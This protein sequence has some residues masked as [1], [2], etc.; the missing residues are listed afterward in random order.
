MNY[1]EAHDNETLFDALTYKL[2]TATSMD[3]R[4]RMQS[5]ALATTALSQG[6]SFWTAGGDQLRSKSFDRN[7]Y[8]S[9]DWFNVLDWS[10]TDNGFGRGLPPAADNEAKWDAMRPLLAEPDLKPRGPTS[11]RPAGRPTRCSRSAAAHPLFALRTRTQVQQKVSFGAGG[12]DQ[13][14][15]VIT[16]RIDDTAARGS[17]GR[18]KGVVVVFNASPEATTQPWRARPAGASPCTRSRPAAAT[19]SSG[20]RRT[21]GRTGPSRCRAGPWRC[22]CSGERRRERPAS[23]PLSRAERVGGR[24]VPSRA[25][26]G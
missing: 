2:P 23:R 12:P 10:K 26:R 14:P 25:R 18:W 7:S 1:V 17:T 11:P 5:L 3:D 9:G 22:S 4:V 13:T 8:D 15:G 16:M 21:T 20:R 19:R 24:R 6:T